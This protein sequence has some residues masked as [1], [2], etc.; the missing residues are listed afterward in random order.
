MLIG[1]VLIYILKVINAPVWVYVIVWV[2]ILFSALNVI[3][4]VIDA[5]L[6]RKRKEKLL[7][8]FLKDFDG[9]E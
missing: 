6:K 2:E 5:E 4:K 1:L 7:K 9:R 8:E 3:L